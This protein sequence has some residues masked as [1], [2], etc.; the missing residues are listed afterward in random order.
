M[1]QLSLFNFLTRPSV[2]HELHAIPGG[3]QQQDV[4]VEPHCPHVDPCY[5]AP[6]A[7]LPQLHQQLVY[8]KSK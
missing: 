5:L 8:I 6:N 4:I 1:N 3:G 7:Q 2:Q